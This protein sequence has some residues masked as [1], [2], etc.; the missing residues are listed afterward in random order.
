MARLVIGRQLLLV[1]GHDH[2]AALGT[3]HHLVFG[4]FKISHGDKAAVDTGGH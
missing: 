1:L 4:I 2:R 3:H